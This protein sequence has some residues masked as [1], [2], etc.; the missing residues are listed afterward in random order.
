[1]KQSLVLIFPVLLAAESCASLL[2]GDMALVGWDATSKGGLSFLALADIEPGETIFF[3]DNEPSA[4]GSGF[5]DQKEGT[6]QLT[7]GPDTITAGTIIQFTDPSG[8]SRASN[9]G[10]LSEAESRFALSPSRDGLWVYQ[11]DE[12]TNEFGGTVSTWVSA[13]ASAAGFGSS[14]VGKIPAG[15]GLVIGENALDL[16]PNHN[17]FEYIGDR[18]IPRSQ[19]EWLLELSDPANFG[20]GYS[21]S[22]ASFSMIPEPGTVLPLACLLT[23]WFLRRRRRR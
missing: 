3:T 11:T 10:L 1:M 2:T 18:T 19:A 17:T 20:P 21:G 4:D 6:L 14:D 22:T 9:F 13:T 16:T 23:P 15:S 7:T 8:S 5:T 12:D